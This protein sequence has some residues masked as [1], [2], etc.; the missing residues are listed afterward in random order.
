[1]QPTHTSSGFTLLELL[2]VL[3]IAALL[4][5]ITGPR[6]STL[7]SSAGFQQQLQ[8]LTTSLKQSRNNANRNNKITRLVLDNEQHQLLRNNTVI[9]SWPEDY[10]LTLI[11]ES[12][13]TVKQPSIIFF[14]AGGSSGGILRL[15]Q[16]NSGQQRQQDI[17]VHWLTGGVHY[18]S[19]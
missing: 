2:V 18:V 6:F 15:T 16:Q 17:S 14:P 19:R 3:A 12:A 10:Q 13:A 5:T 11:A 9:F 4:I 1:M 7:Q 8:K